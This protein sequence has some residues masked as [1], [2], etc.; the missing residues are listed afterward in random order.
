MAMA[1]RALVVSQL[2]PKT[3]AIANDCSKRF[4]VG[5]QSVALPLK[6]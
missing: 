1:G 5:S 2:F 6:Y 3:E 4:S